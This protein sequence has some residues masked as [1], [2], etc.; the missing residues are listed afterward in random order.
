MTN[1]FVILVLAH[2]HTFEVALCVAAW[3][4]LNKGLRTIFMALVIPSHVPLHK[5]PGATGIQLLFAGLF[6]LTAGP[7][8]G[9][10][11]SIY[12]KSCD[13]GEI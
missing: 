7:I 6:Y 2:S 3:I 11:I 10:S 8:V 12:T 1:N 4:G 9:K 5:L 13:I